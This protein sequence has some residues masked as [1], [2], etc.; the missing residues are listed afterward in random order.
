MHNYKRMI[1]NLQRGLNARGYKILV[2]RSQFYSEEAKVP[3]TCH[4]VSFAKW[5]EEKQQNE[6]VEIFKTYKEIF[7]VFFLRN[8]WYFVNDKEI[9][10]SRNPIKGE[11]KFE[12]LWDNFVKDHGVYFKS[13]N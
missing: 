3:I 7:L 8:L 5:N 2:G 6:N 9:P 13:I 1:F 12:E 4:R 11:D 10:H